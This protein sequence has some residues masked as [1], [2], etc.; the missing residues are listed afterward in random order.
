MQAYPPPPPPPK[1]KKKKSAGH[2]V[3][4]LILK[5]DTTTCNM[6]TQIFMM[7]HIFDNFYILGRRTARD[8][9]R[10]FG[11]APGVPHSKT[12]YVPLV[13]VLIILKIRP[14]DIVN[15]QFYSQNSCIWTYEKWI[16]FLFSSPE[17]KAH[18]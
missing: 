17:P 5:S 3:S 7:C 15:D 4:C 16:S 10:H 6:C 12:A 2:F 1:K 13:F 18:G 9:Y 14:P 8:A 11:R